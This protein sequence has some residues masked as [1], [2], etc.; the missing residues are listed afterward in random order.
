MRHLLIHFLLH[1]SPKKSRLLLL[2]LQ[3]KEDIFRGI[4]SATLPTQLAVEVNSLQHCTSHSLRNWTNCAPVCLLCPNF[5]DSNYVCLKSW[6]RALLEWWVLGWF[7]LKN[8]WYLSPG[9]KLTR[10]VCIPTKLVKDAWLANNC[11]YGPS[12]L[13]RAF[14]SNPLF[15]IPFQPNSF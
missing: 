8:L 9:C 1:S 4:T 13:N 15:P 11:M 12:T 2:T 6:E 10:A 5:R 7:Y 14:V 3:H